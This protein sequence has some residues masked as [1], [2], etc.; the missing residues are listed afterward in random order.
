MDWFR[1]VHFSRLNLR[2]LFSRRAAI[3]AVMAIFLYLGVGI[4]YKAL[5]LRFVRTGPPPAAEVKAPAVTLAAREP[6]DAYRAV[7]ERNLFGTTTK[8][9]VEKP[10]GAPP[11]LDAALLFEVRGTVAGEGKYG[12]AILEERGTRKQRLVKAGDVVAGAKVIRIRRNAVDVLMEGQERTLKMAEMKEA[13]ILPSA[14]TAAAAGPPPP[15]PA[16]GTLVVNRS[17]IQEAMEDMG[18]ILSQAQI[19]PFFTMGVP[20]GFMVTSIRPGSI[21]QKMGIANGDIIQEVN[22]RKIQTADDM[23]GLLAIL[24]SGNEM[25]MMVKRGGAPRTMMYQFR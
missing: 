17:E 4:F 2:G 14:V 11:P 13:P 15:P 18:S 1:Y 23:S 16:P 20:D 24:K 3:L 19:R 8:V 7:P 25:S 5:A 21:Y 10:V 6:V 22:N 12:F 9:V